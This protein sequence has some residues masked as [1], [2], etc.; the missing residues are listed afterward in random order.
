MTLTQ[1]GRYQI[2]EELG[3]GAMGVVYKALDPLIE[4]TVALKTI[5]CQGLSRDE[6]ETFERR[7]FFE[8]KSAGRLNHPNIVTIHDVGRDG[9]LAYIAMEFLEGRSLRELLDSGVVLPGE[10]IADIAIQVAT[11]LAF[12]HGNDVVHRDIKPANVMVLDNGTVKI[13]DFGVAL[14]PTGS[15]THAG[16]A[17]G[18]PKYMSPE[19][20]RG[21]K[22]DGRSDIF[23][24]GA[25]VYEMITGLPPFRG[26]EL[27]AIL[28]QVLETAPPPPSSRRRKL[29]P[30]FDTIVA[31]A[32]AKD[33]AQ[34]Y[35][36]AEEMAAE[37]RRCLEREGD[38]PAASAAPPN[39]AARAESAGRRRHRLLAA[40]AA[41]TA[42]VALGI[43][44]V[45]SMG[46]GRAASTIAPAENAIAA[47]GKAKRAKPIVAAASPAPTTLKARPVR[48]HLA[49]STLG[50]LEVDVSPWGE[51]YVD[52]RRRGATPP[53]LKIALAPGRHVVEIRR[54]GSPT[55]REVITL[56]AH[57]TARIEHRFP[58]LV[59]D[60]P[61][62]SP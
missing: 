7:F 35:Q 25:V 50:R 52:G 24:L 58:T 34:R 18:S 3:R 60:S 54:V 38:R 5:S 56:R 12:A 36:S 61:L 20:V 41:A 33:P 28:H 2:I 4:R 10:R 14:L 6:V 13:A 53:A 48:E 43:V 16:T 30:L 37:L 22:V 45:R 8:A 29:H 32:M 26:E 15:M 1:L 9:D 47:V 11:G 51:V 17:F 57:E 49:A 62:Y 55:R 19:Q 40:G 23:S 44:G 27:G 39:T 42:L 59:T 21:Q 46:P 31:R